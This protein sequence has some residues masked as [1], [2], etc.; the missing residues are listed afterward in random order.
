MTGAEVHRQMYAVE[1]S[2]R[3]FA[4]I[5]KVNEDKKMML[6]LKHFVGNDY[7]ATN[8]KEEQEMLELLNQKVAENPEYPIPDGYKKVSEVIIEDSYQVPDG[9]KESEQVALQ[10]LDDIFVRTL[11]VHILDS[12]P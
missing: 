1:L 8:N 12:V 3:L 4:T 9:K 7:L 11:G 10:V 2:E 5:K 6:A